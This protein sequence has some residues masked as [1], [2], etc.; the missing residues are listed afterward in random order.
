MKTYP[1]KE[2]QKWATMRFAGGVSGV[3]LLIEILGPEKIEAVLLELGISPT[4][5]MLLVAV[6]FAGLRIWKQENGNGA[7]SEK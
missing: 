5:A 7:E 1:L 3:M 4:R 6:I 2:A